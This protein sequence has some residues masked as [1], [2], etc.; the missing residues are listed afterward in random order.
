[1]LD[2]NQN[3]DYPNRDRG[4][5]MDLIDK[6]FTAGVL[7]AVFTGAG[8]VGSTVLADRYSVA[9]FLTCGF[10]SAVGAGKGLQYAASKF[11][12]EEED[13][14]HWKEQ[15]PWIRPQ[16]RVITEAEQNA[17]FKQF[18]KKSGGLVNGLFLGA[19]AGLLAGHMVMTGVRYFKPLPP[20]PAHPVETTK[21]IEELGYWNR[22][23]SP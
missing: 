15:N 20:E 9:A 3:I 19:A 23:V 14:Q 22:P 16:D 13:E 18:M 2:S 8:V 7:S 1:M 12:S 4:Q 11:P 17:R 10:L 6:I 5:P 21:K